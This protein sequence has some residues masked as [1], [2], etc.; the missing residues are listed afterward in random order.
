MASPTRW[1]W[2][3]VNSGSWWWT[4]RPGVLWFMGSQRVG[5]DWV[6]ELT[7]WLKEKQSACYWAELVLWE[8]KKREH[9]TSLMLSSRSPIFPCLSTNFLPSHTRPVACCS[10][11]RDTH[12]Q[13]LWALSYPSPDSIKDSKSLH[14]AN[15]NF[16]PAWLMKKTK[17][18]WDFELVHSLRSSS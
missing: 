15:S 2:V 18:F 12:P 17:K 9:R 5:H 13:P 1:T 11:P 4:G 16:S 3:W 7:D 14:L 8:G 6:T 10:I